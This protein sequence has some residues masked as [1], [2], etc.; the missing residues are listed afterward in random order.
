[1]RQH[2]FIL[3]Q[4][5]HPLCCLS[6]ARLPMPRFFAFLSPLRAYPPLLLTYFYLLRRW[7]ERVESASPI[8]LTSSLVGGTPGSLFLRQLSIDFHLALSPSWSGEGF[9]VCFDRGCPRLQ[10]VSNVGKRRSLI[11]PSSR[12]PRLLFQVLWDASNG[13]SQP[14]LGRKDGLRVAYWNVRTPK[15]SLHAGLKLSISL[16]ACTTK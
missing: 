5:P 12:R 16:V 2:S 9:Q 10:L 8:E 3:S 1:M 13:Q 4:A 14:I 7:P 11:S 6:R 15:R